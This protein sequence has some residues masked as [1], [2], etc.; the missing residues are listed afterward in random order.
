MN[1]IDDILKEALDKVKEAQNDVAVENIKIEYLGKK[2]GITEILKTL[3]T[4][5]VEEKKEVGSHINTAKK[6]FK[7]GYRR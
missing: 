6:C 5:S 2:G 7:R 1:R 3:S 4:L